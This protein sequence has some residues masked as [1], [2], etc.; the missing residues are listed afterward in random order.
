MAKSRADQLSKIAAVDSAM[1]LISWKLF[2]FMTQNVPLLGAETYMNMKREADTTT[3]LGDTE[4]WF[5]NTYPYRQLGDLQSRRLTLALAV[6]IIGD[7]VAHIAEYPKTN[8][9]TGSKHAIRAISSCLRREL[10]EKKSNIKVTH[11][12]QVRES[13]Q[14]R[15]QWDTNKNIDVVSFIGT[16]KCRLKQCG[17]KAMVEKEKG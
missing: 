7:V 9:Y 4:R 13:H 16:A 11:K 2:Y 14:Y 1:S 8:V 10:A 5:M 6:E 15:P 3:V 17:R 12:S